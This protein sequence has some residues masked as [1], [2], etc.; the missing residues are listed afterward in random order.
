MPRR[1][2]QPPSAEWEALLRGYE[3]T[4][5]LTPSER[6]AIPALATLRAVWVMALPATPGTTWGQEWLLD[7]EYL[8]AHVAMIER[9]ASLAQRAMIR[10]TS[11]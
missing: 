4:R 7:P 6:R 2:P 3:Q 10:P 1:A 5:V 11:G 9:L 8:D